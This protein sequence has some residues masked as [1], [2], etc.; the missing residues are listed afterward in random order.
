MN[1]EVIEEVFILIHIRY[2]DKTPKETQLSD[3]Y[4]LIFKL[5]TKQRSFI[6]TKNQG[7]ASYADQ[8]KHC[9]II[10]ML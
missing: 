5:S 8:Y 9:Q 7:S 2:H 1:F 10:G 3:S 6:R 4:S